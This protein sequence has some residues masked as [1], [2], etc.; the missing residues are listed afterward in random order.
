MCSLFIWTVVIK[1]QNIFSLLTVYI[2]KMVGVSLKKNY[3][4][5]SIVYVSIW[6][7]F[8]PQFSSD[9]KES[10]FCSNFPII[11]II[12]SAKTLPF[13]H[14]ISDNRLSQWIL[15]CHLIRDRPTDQPTDRYFR[16]VLNYNSLQA[17]FLILPKTNTKCYFH[18]PEKRN[19]KFF[20]N[21]LN[22]SGIYIKK[23]A[24]LSQLIANN[25]LNGHVR[26]KNNCSCSSE[27]SL[28]FDMK[29]WNNFGRN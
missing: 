25:H 24:L 26:I 22:I 11:F 18:F 21:T 4:R 14:V 28:N 3:I 1:V 27:K 16:R 19:L 23:K 29:S 12:F 5:Y 8:C 13:C 20:R 15:L 17:I 9:C 2:A 6:L 10:T 7:L